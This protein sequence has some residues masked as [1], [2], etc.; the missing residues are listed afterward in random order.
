MAGRYDDVTPPLDSSSHTE[1][2]HVE[3][4]DRHVRKKPKTTAVSSRG[5]RGVASLTPEQLAKKRAVD[6]EAQRAIRERT[7]GQIEKLELQVKELTAQQPYQDLQAVIRQKDAIQA[8]NDE[9]KWKLAS[10]IQTLQSCIGST[11][12]GNAIQ[13]AL[14]T[15]PN[16]WLLA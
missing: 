3:E 4:D 15:A 10:V 12:S 1:L 5:D 9:L 14:N 7:K 11:G 6:R 2:P 16:L 8:D 13:H